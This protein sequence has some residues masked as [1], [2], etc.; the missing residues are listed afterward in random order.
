MPLRPES[1]RLDPVVDQDPFADAIWNALRSSHQH[2]ALSCGQAAKYPMDIA[3]FAALAKGT[4]E[5]IRDLRTLMKPGETTY[6][7]GQPPPPLDGIL[8]R[9]MTPCLQMGF[10][11]GAPLPSSTT[12]LA[13]SELTCAD[14]SAMVALTDVAFPGFFRSRTCLM[15]RYFGIWHPEDTGKLVAMAGERLVLS[16]SREI[17]GVCTDPAF[18]GRGLAAALTAHLVR[19][20]RQTGAR[21]VLHVL[22]TN[23]PA[24]RIYER[25]GFTVLREIHLHRL[26][27]AD[28][29]MNTCSPVDPR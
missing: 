23:L 28:Q 25:L 7:I 8:Y 26:K 18:R 4:T 9:G 27:R 19:H 3:P 29:E 22:S 17:S 14:A 5:A 20:H 13:I 16:P 10:P 24:I 21:S 11:G 15:G 12:E 1:G 6:V 2:L